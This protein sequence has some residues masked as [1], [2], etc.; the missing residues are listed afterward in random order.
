MGA[1]IDGNWRWSSTAVSRESWWRASSRR[2]T[3]RAWAWVSGSH[4][5]R[6]ATPLRNSNDR[7]PVEVSQSPACLVQQV[8]NG[9]DNSETA[10]MS[11]P[12]PVSLLVL[13]V[14]QSFPESAAKRARYACQDTFELTGRAR[15]KCKLLEII[16]PQALCEHRTA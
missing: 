16:V 12:S 14:E 3:S 7:I 5:R 4:D 6:L 1:S 8:N 13:D 11:A 10:G 9:F 2:R 15:I